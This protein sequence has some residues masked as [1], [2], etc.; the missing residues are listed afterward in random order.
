MDDF[1]FSSLFNRADL[2]YAGGILERLFGG[3]IPFL[4]GDADGLGAGNWLST[5]FGTFN[6]AGLL[7]VLVVTS[8]T[9]YTVISDTASDGQ[10][11]GQQTNTKYTVLRAM[12][13][14]ISFIPVTGG[15]SL[16]Q[17][18]ILWLVIQGS[19][20]GDVVWTRTA[21]A[22]LSGQPLMVAPQNQSTNDFL[23]QG[24]FA[25]AF[26]ALVA[27]HLCAINANAIQLS[28]GGEELDDD[29]Y[30]SR[31][32]SGPLL[33]HSSPATE[34]RTS[35][36]WLSIG[37]KEVAT[38]NH[39][40]LFREA[41]GSAAYGGRANFC[42]GVENSASI[43]LGNL[44]SSSY[45]FA[46]QVAAV[47]TRSQ[48]QNYVNVINQMSGR[49]QSLALAIHNGQ[50]DV[51]TM[52][53]QSRATIRAA[54]N[55]YVAGSASQLQFSTGEAQALH[56]HLLNDAT[57]RGWVFAVGWQRG[58]SMAASWYGSPDGDLRIRAH[59][60]NNLTEYLS[61]QGLRT[62]WRADGTTR[63]MLSKAA[64][65]FEV[66]DMMGGYLNSLSE[67]GTDA[68]EESYQGLTTNNRMAGTIMN[69]V[70]R[71]LLDL[72]NPVASS[73]G[74]SGYVDPMVQVTQ[75]G[76]NL[77]IA[78]GGMAGLAAASSVVNWVPGL[79]GIA[80]SING[81]L[82]TAGIAIA[83]FGFIVSTMVPMIPFVFFYSAVI[84]WVLLVVESMFAVGL[85]VLTL[86][87]P[88]REGTLI[89]SWNRILLSL[90]GIFFRPF[91][92]VVGLI[93]A[94]MVISFALQYLYDLFYMLMDFMVPGESWFSIFSLVGFLAVYV[95][96]TCVT[97]LI[98]SQL[99]TELG[100]GAMNWLGV[101][102]GS[103]ANRMDVGREAT[104][105]ANLSPAG[106]FSRRAAMG[107]NGGSNPKLG[108]KLM[109]GNRGSGNELPPAAQK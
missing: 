67:P 38:I 72:F 43:R 92:T 75:Q 87:A 23:I 13:G 91:F 37:G 76:K 40:V 20:L 15:Y 46:D 101:T 6:T 57:Q 11:F 50:R 65:D 99:I 12:A 109:T 53:E 27:G 107:I 85:A 26:D 22:A 88:A 102:F 63:A 44:T 42:G 28:M 18:S 95:I 52:E 4:K 56:Q 55:A 66:W 79:G 36:N 33:A 60:E 100:D 14:F 108:R 68:E 25:Q 103:I 5:I 74:N 106:S 97:V 41:E 94:M 32:V 16:L 83:A 31:V 80:E 54:T 30:S 73:S 48:F 96:V 3:I 19:A 34:E 78:G 64:N 90:F 62:G 49:A 24:Q 81:P 98:G 59:R 70:Y 9:V 105:A 77:M 2:D 7:A 45:S 8:Y 89:G 17:V 1:D 86:F 47:R 29:E 51:P 93:F 69:W 21:D 58:I 35:P 10:T 104:S 84:S 82:M 71:S 39:V 61:G